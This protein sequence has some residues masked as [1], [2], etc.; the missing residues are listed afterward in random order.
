M[1]LLISLKNKGKIIYAQPDF[2][3]WGKEECLDKF[4]V[5]RVETNKTKAEL[6]QITDDIDSG[7]PFHKYYFDLDNAFTEAEWSKMQNS[8]WQVYEKDESFIRENI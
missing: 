7:L 2:S 3:S 1:E 6:L 8:D 4:V 5:V